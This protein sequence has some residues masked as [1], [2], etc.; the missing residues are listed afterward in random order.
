MIS[1]DDP[2]ST[3]SVRRDGLT[4]RATAIAEIRPALHVGLPQPQSNPLQPGVTP[5]ALL[6]TCIQNVTGAQ[7]TINATVNPATGVIT[8]TNAGAPPCPLAGTVVGRFVANPTAISTVGRALPAPANVA[9]TAVNSFAGRYG[10]VYS[11]MTSGTNRIIGF[12]RITWTRNTCPTTPGA[13]FTATI[14]RGVSLVAASNATG[15]LIGGL[16]LPASAQPAEVTEL[17]DKNR[18]GP[19]RV[20]YGPVFVPV[21]AR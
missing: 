10:P 21:L 20:N 12:S 8:R 1:G 18:I 6:D 17:L 5:F 2:S 16:P 11:L 7:V 3:Y 9:C 4:V 19:G 14:A 13:A 15:S